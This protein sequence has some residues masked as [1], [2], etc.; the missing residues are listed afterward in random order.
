MIFGFSSVFAQDC[1]TSR[2]LGGELW[3]MRQSK[4]EKQYELDKWKPQR[5]WVRENVIDRLTLSGEY[6]YG[7]ESEL[8]DPNGRDWNLKPKKNGEVKIS[9]TLPIGKLFQQES[10][11]SHPH[12]EYSKQLAVDKAKIEFDNLI[13]DWRVANN[14]LE[15]KKLE[16]VDKLQSSE[17]DTKKIAVLEIEAA[18][19]AVDK[20]STQIKNL[21]GKTDTLI[22]CI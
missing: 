2:A 9:Y 7:T 22:G 6:S 8:K 13:A 16:L 1:A 10:S 14:L 19:Y 17:P 5:S 20:L 15:R 3:E 18:Q 12:S 21:S 11:E 4:V